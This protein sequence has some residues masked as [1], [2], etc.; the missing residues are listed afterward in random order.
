MGKGNALTLRLE[1]SVLCCKE[2][3]SMGK[4]LA[5]MDF[6]LAAVHRWAHE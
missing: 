2:V 6:D 4:G 3:E 5:C 1:M